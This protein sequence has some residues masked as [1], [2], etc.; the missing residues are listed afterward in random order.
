[1]ICPAGLELQFPSR[2]S[3]CAQF[4]A[5]NTLQAADLCQG[6]GGLSERDIKLVIEGGYHT[7]E[8]VAMTCD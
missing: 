3:R 8:A 6:V 1:M 4:K 7:V 2:S 5:Q